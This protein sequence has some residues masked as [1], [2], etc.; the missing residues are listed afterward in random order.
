[1]R[2]ANRKTISDEFNIRLIG[3]TENN[4]LEILYRAPLFLTYFGLIANLILLLLALMSFFNDDF[5]LDISYWGILGILLFFGLISFSQRSIKSLFDKEKGKLTMYWGGIYFTRIFEN[6]S[7]KIISDIKIVGIRRY[8]KRYGDGFQV[9]LLM[10]PD[11]IL[12]ITGD[13]LK[14]SEAQMCA[15]TIKEFL[16][17]EEKIKIMD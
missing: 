4:F 5:S 9:F 17:I 6:T 2:Y 7:V 10:H 12:D 15:E 1:M 16:K 3:D 13:N 11:T 8:V 14:P